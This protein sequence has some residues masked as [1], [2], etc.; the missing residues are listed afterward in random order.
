MKDLPAKVK[1]T[2]TLVFD[3]ATQ[4][5]DEPRLQAFEGTPALLQ[6]W[7]QQS[8]VATL[9]VEFDIPEELRNPKELAIDSLQKQIEA[10]KARSAMVLRELEDQIQ[11]LLALPNKE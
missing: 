6:G 7:L 2:I 9:E 10:E 8:P 1:K 11:Q 5:G 3:P 4:F